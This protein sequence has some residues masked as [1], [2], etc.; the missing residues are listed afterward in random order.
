VW[1]TA[2]GGGV[3]LGDASSVGST[4]GGTLLLVLLLEL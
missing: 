1:P 3:G 4:A 2:E